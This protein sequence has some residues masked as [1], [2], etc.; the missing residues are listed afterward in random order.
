VRIQNINDF[1]PSWGERRNER[2]C[3]YRICSIRSNWRTADK[4]GSANS[5]RWPEYQT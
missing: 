4:S 5:S 2:S 1:P 3:S